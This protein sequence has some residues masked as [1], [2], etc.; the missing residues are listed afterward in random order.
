MLAHR[1]LVNG[2]YPSSTPDVRDR[3]Q[4]LVNPTKR[5]TT[6]YTR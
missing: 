6:H 2:M 1:M 3:S 4:A 5:L